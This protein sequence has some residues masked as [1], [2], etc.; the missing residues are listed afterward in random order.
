M[1]EDSLSIVV[2]AFR[3]IYS[4]ASKNSSKLGYMYEFDCRPSVYVGGSLA[5]NWMKIAFQ[6]QV[7][8]RRFLP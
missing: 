7:T 1:F 2:P 8:S 5:T 4:Q 3:D 6:H